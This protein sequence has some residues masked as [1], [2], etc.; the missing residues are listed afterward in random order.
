MTQEKQSNQNDYFI[1]LIYI[2]KIFA[3]IYL[4]AIL[5]NLIGR[6]FWKMGTATGLEPLSN[7][8]VIPL[9]FSIIYYTSR[10]K[11]TSLSKALTIRPLYYLSI[12]VGNMTY[13]ST[14]LEYRTNIQ[15]E[16]LTEFEKGKRALEV[17]FRMPVSGL[18]LWFEIALGLAFIFFAFRIIDRHLVPK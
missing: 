11:E 12:L 2:G 14:R 10:I 7:M 13:L 18:I 15:W 9:Y 17:G 8:F 4:P 1:K 6:Q 5:L 3:L 16:T